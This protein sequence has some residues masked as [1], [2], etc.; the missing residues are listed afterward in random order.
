M[1]EMTQ[2]EKDRE[3]AE[4]SQELLGLSD[5]TLAVRQ[6]IGEL[7]G[8]SAPIAVAVKTPKKA[9]ADETKAAI[10]NTDGTPKKKRG[11]PAGSGKKKAEEGESAGRAG[12]LAEVLKTIAKESKTSLLLADFVKKSLEAGYESN[13]ED[14]SNVVYQALMKLKNSGVFT[15]DE[16]T[17]GYSYAAA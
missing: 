17:M 10:T 3:V 7:L 13:S 4:L 16:E 1:V 12:S 5:R 11:R 2:A 14:F 6:R 8:F 9:K 15:R